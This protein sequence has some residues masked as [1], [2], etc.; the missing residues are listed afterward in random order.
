MD[1][2]SSE[3]D[4]L[5]QFVDCVIMGPYSAAD[6]H[7]SFKSATDFAVPQYHRNAPESRAFV[8]GRPTGG[9]PLR[10][11]VIAAVEERIGDDAL[12]SVKERALVTTQSVRSMFHNKQNLWYVQE[13]VFACLLYSR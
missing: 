8:P 13:H 5:H 1:S 9:S 3:Q 10:R 6:L 2:F 4:E 11:S 7:A 12:K